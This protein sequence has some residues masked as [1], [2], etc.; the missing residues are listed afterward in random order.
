MVES[1]KAI[2]QQTQGGELLQTIVHSSSTALEGQ[3]SLEEHLLQKLVWE[4]A[5][6]KQDGAI[7]RDLVKELIS[8][9]INPINLPR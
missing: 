5:K 7:Q 9:Q 2:I 4:E 8:V 1:K 6:L 3:G